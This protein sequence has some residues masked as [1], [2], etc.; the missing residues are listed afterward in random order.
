VNRYD[1]PA[2]FGAL[3]PVG[4]ALKGVLITLFAVWLAFALGINWTPD[5]LAKSLETMFRALAGDT[6]GVLRGE[7]W[8]LF[9]APLLHS[10]RDL[11]SIL[12]A[13]LGLYF[14]SPSLESAWG[15]RRFVAFLLGSAVFA[16][17]FQAVAVL[18]LPDAVGARLVGPIWFGSMPAIEAIAI[19]WARSF[20]GR[21]VRLFFVLPVSSRGL[22]LFVIG[23]SVLSVVVLAN[24]ASGLIAPF[25]G[26]LAGF[27]FGEHPSPLRRW[28]LKQKLSRAERELERIAENRKQRVARAP[29]RVISGGRDA[30]A[31]EDERGTPSGPRGP[32]GKLLN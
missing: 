27:L 15:P 13:L 16:Y 26:I 12:F 3:P 17:L 28:W 7:V 24:T 11:S 2:G 22:V 10:P 14:L 5:P 1:E 9:T 23:M 31:D 4:P 6:A 18:L 32:D 30:A 8:R 19:A 21:T 20:R 29:F 25:G